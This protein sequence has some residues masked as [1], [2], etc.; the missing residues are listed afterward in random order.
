MLAST[1]F[2]Q[3][4]RHC[5]YVMNLSG[6]TLRAYESDLRKFL[7]QAPNGKKIAQISKEDLRGYL[8]YLRAQTY[9]EASIKRYIATLK[10]MFCWA[11]REEIL[12]SNPFDTLDERIRIPKRL[13]RALDKG[14]TETLR[15]TI[16]TKN[17]QNQFDHMSQKT[18]IQML[19]GTGIRVS[20]LSSIKL[21][22]I[23]L[24]DRCLVIQG[25]GNRQRLVYF[26][27][28]KL[29]EAIAS[30]LQIRW[31]IKT[32]SVNL[33]VTSRGGI[34]T[35]AKVRAALH[36]FTAEAGISRRITPHML[37]HTCAT[38]WLEAGLDIRY[39]QKLLGHQSISTTEIYTH[40]SD[41]GLR[42]ALT[43]L[44]DDN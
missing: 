26:L 16:D 5:Q 6:H 43:R 17:L 33:F 41:H 18:A 4:L 9:K 24:S 42:T 7:Q 28:K 15:K 23:S 19:L 40:V 35:P 29:H 8:R 30:Y 39:V 27:S 12:S 14:C 25:K 38:H 36:R 32:N 31:N 10:A 11:Y 20:E 3:F 34:L 2:S 13:P 21:G 22:D 44:A 1:A 37:R